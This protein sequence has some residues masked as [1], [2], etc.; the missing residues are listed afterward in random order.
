M[1]L[2]L[3]RP[4]AEGQ[5]AAPS[6]ELET[7]SSQTSTWFWR[8]WCGGDRKEKWQSQVSERDSTKAALSLAKVFRCTDMR[9]FIPKQNAVQSTWPWPKGLIFFF[10]WLSPSLTSFSL[11]GTVIGVCKRRSQWQPHEDLKKYNNKISNTSLMRNVGCTF[12]W[13]DL[14][15]SCK[16]SSKGFTETG[17][18]HLNSN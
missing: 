2:P 12:T 5:Q 16:Y 17:I 15:E 13:A 6:Q 1:D 18:F 10:Q 14:E 11:P 9:H 3:L 8:E 4:P 7:G